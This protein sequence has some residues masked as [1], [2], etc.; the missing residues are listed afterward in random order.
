[1]P[2]PRCNKPAPAPETGGGEAAEG[3]QAATTPASAID[4]DSIVR[5]VTG[6]VTSQLAQTLDERFNRLAATLPGSRADNP[7]IQHR[8]RAERD[9]MEA[10]RL[11]RLETMRNY[12]Y[13]TDSPA[14]HPV[15]TPPAVPAFDQLH[16]ELPFASATPS[17]ARRHAI[18]PEDIGTFDGSSDRLE[19]FL[20]R[21]NALVQ[22]RRDP[23]WEAAIVDILPLCLCDTAA[24]WYQLLGPHQCIRLNTAWSDWEA[25][26]QKAFQPDASEIRRIADERRWDWQ[27]E[28]IAAYFYAKLSL[29]CAAYPTRLHADLVHKICLGLP[30]SLQ[31]DVRSHMAPKPSMDD[32]LME[33]RNLEGPWRAALRSGSCPT[34]RHETVTSS[35][36]TS[37]QYGP[38]LAAPTLTAPTTST[39]QNQPESRG[40]PPSTANG[41]NSGRTS[42]AA[43]YVPANVTYIHRDGRKVRAYKLPHS[44]QYIY[45]GRP[46]RT[47]SQDHFDFKHKF[48]SRQPK[49]EAHLIQAELDLVQAYG[50]P[51]ICLNPIYV[52]DEE[53]PTSSPDLSF[54][55]SSSGGSHSNSSSV[56]IGQSGGASTQPRAITYPSSG[57]DRTATSQ[58]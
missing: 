45:L 16:D 17:Q 48:V 27:K 57:E 38:P 51:M 55:S 26:L 40:Q 41:Q 29:L 53:S 32:L 21:V 54:T 30:A 39:A 22:S 6:A 7:D 56:A 12:G 24:Q 8:R 18:K 47:C 36:S 14:M 42:L 34:T 4:I 50:Y 19:F 49:A 31:L 44:G 46:C 10:A 5:A 58:N 3:S 28:S 2:N 9:A 37:S 20:G 33:L 15:D 35:M 1:M 13:K 11:A 23:T 52:G 25:A 43:G